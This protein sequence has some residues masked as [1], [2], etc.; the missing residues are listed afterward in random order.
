MLAGVNCHNK[1]TSVMVLDGV[2]S[3][4]LKRHVNICEI[5]SL[6]AGILQCN[7]RELKEAEGLKCVFVVFWLFELK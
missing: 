6:L 7:G 2:R 5:I 3:K 1:M 4:T